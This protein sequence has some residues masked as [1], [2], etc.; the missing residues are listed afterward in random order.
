[1]DPKE[2]SYYVNGEKWEYNIMRVSGIFTIL[3]VGKS[4]RSCISKLEY[5]DSRMKE[6]ACTN[7]DGKSFLGMKLP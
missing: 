6:A 2:D 7:T 1:M 4:Q 3:R 5:D